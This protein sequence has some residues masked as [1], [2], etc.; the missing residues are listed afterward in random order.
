[1]SKQSFLS[2]FQTV[3]SAVAF[4]APIA[5]QIASSFVPGGSTAFMILGDLQRYFPSIVQFMQSRQV[6]REAQH[7]NDDTQGATKAAEVTADLNAF[8]KPI[9]DIAAVQGKTVSHDAQAFQ[10]ANT[11]QITAYNSWAAWV[12]TIEIK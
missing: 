10:K 1:M 11:D 5:I 8:L 2:G 3:E 4:F 6:I 12:R 7:I 9:Q